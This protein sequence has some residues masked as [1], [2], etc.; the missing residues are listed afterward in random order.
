MY[1]AWTSVQWTYRLSYMTSVVCTMYSACTCTS[2]QVCSE[3]STDWVTCSSVQC[4]QR[5]T[6]YSAWS[7]D[8]VTCSIV[9]WMHQ[10]TVNAVLSAD[11]FTCTCAH[12]MH[13]CTVYSECSVDLVTW[14]V[15]NVQCM[16]QCTSVEWMQ[17]WLSYMYQYT[18]Q[19]ECIGVLSECSVDIELHVS[20]YSARTSVHCTLSDVLT[21]LDTCTSMQCT[22][23]HLGWF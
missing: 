10:C 18:V 19:I 2:V 13:Q 12:C 8:W 11:W 22:L 3:C 16:H 20:V 17:C 9:Q 15:Y 4:M 23:H 14:P 21:E 7:I 1:S 5:C 6:V